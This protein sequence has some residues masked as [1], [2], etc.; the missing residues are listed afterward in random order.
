[1]AEQLP[2]RLILASGS[3]ARREL[4]D[5]AGYRFEVCPAGV[6]EPTGVGVKDIRAFVQSVAWMKA[7]AVAP[8]FAEG[9]VL[10][11]DTVGWVDGQVM[12]KPADA[13]DARRILRL[14]GGREHELWTGVVLWR[15][16]D[17]VQLAWQERSRV[18]LRALSDA[19]LEVYLATRQ[20]RENS[21]A[22][23][24]Q[25]PVDPYLRVAAGSVSNVI[26]LPMETTKLA[27]EWIAQLPSLRQTSS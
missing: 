8:R 9:V 6:D 3:P 22:Y 26:G 20:W 15:R 1:M 4:L 21:G 12:G 13:M 25:E 23:A 16:P 19:E 5:R 27:L 7:A 11:A 18:F 17:D 14:I 2:L 10:A 24:I